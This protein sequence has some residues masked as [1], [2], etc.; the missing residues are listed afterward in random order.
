MPDSG[1]RQLT[2]FLRKLA[3][4]YYQ[5]FKAD[6]VFRWGESWKISEYEVRAWLRAVGAGNV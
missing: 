5:F 3:L 4:N 2:L 6:Y 1:R